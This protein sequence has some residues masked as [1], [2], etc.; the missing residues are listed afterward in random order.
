LADY[1]R[2]RHQHANR[3][4]TPL[5]SLQAA[6]ANCEQIDWAN[7]QPSKPKFIGRRV[8]KNYSLAEIAKFIDWTPFFQTWDLAGKFPAILDD[9]VVGVEAR[10][11]YQDAQAMLEK[12]IKGQWLQAD[13]IIG[14]FPAN[15]DGDDILFYADEER[16]QPFLVW[17]N[18]RQQ[19]ERPVVDGVMRPNRCLADYVASKG[20]GVRDYAGCFAVTTGHGVDEKVAQFMAKHDDYSAIMLK[21]LADR[22]A[23]AFAELMHWRVRTDLWGYVANEELTPED[24][25]DEKYQ[26]IRPAPGYPA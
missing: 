3:K 18:L 26:G 5:I 25:I 23:E 11:V 8:F 10:R 13:A 7:T 2:I 15:S 21:A 24:L 9:E 17:H 6:R 12:L 4:S 16:S 20:S 19:A 22:L 14:L 1:E